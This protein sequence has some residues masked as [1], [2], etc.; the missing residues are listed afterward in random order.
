[1]VIT[2]S[3]DSLIAVHRLFREKYIPEIEQHFLSLHDEVSFQATL[4]H[5][6][7]H[8]FIQVKNDLI[9]HFEEEEQ[10]VFPLV[11]EYE[12]GNIT[13]LSDHVYRFLNEHHVAEGEVQVILQ[14]LQCQI[15]QLGDFLP[16]RMLIHKLNA[17][18]QL[19]RV[20]SEQ[21]EMVFQKVVPN[22]SEN[23]PIMKLINN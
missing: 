21:E 20:H 1:M 2:P 12:N 10:F 15:D 11:K 17:L 5:L 4:L 9:R 18:Q 16:Y 6:S 8:Q 3:I 23:K 14:L 22:F 13:E 19:V 7:Y